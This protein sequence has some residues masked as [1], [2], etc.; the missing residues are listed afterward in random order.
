MIH[1]IPDEKLKWFGLKDRS[2]SAKAGRGRCRYGSRISSAMVSR[3]VPGTPPSHRMNDGVRS[4]TSDTR[5]RLRATVTVPPIGRSLRRLHPNCRA[6]S[7]ATLASAPNGRCGSRASRCRSSCSAVR[8]RRARPSAPMTAKDSTRT[9][10]V[11][12]TES[13][14]SAARSSSNKARAAAAPS[15]NAACVSVAS[16]K[17]AALR[18]RD[19]RIA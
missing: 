2:Q 17:P 13:R 8:F 14:V 19:M 7:V 12:A 18:R 6:R 3:D 5:R 4:A 15:L 16:L 10:A 1:A 9:D 11:M